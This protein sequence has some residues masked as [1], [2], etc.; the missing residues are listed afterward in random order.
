MFIVCSELEMR[1]ADAPPMPPEIALSVIVG[2]L[3]LFLLVAF[4][5]IRAERGR[6]RAL[7][8][9]ARAEERTR[10][11]EAGLTDFAG[12]RV[13]VER[14]GREQA[15]LL[16]ERDQLRALNSELRTVREERDGLARTLEREH[17][18]ARGLERQIADLKAAKEE[19]RQ[20]FNETA[21]VLFA[22]HSETF[23]AQNS[24]QIGHL[25]APLKNDLDAFKKSLGDAHVEASKQHGS[26]KEQIEL[27]ARQSA[28]VSKEAENL[29]RALKGGVQMQGAWGEMIVDTILNR[30]GLREGV[31]FTRQESFAD[32]EG[33]ARTDYIVRLPQGDAVVIDSKVSLVDYERYVNAADDG[34]R[35]QHLAA[36]ARSLRTHVKGLASKDYHAKVGTRLDFVIMFVP[37]EAALGVA[38]SNDETLTLD[39]LDQK[40][41][42]AT[43]TTLTTTIQT[44]AAMWKV[45]RQNENA[46]AIADRAG[47]L[48]DKFVN[49]AGDLAD[50]GARIAQAGGAYDKAL[51]KLSGAGGLVRQAEMLK[52]MGAK[53][54]K[55]LPQDL[56]ERAG[57]ADRA[58][59]LRIDKSSAEDE[60][61]PTPVQ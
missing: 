31:E 29:A 13:E 43:P 27:L 15:A 40:V 20:S 8:A 18:E 26:L 39:A 7:A 44:I 6:A 34:A 52:A 33:R 42:I 54:S 16:T 23:K 28:S 58:E 2:A 25:L 4:L 56:L 5:I 1:L 9:L 59:L 32:A 50:I 49:F 51:T 55:S 21:G 47:K 41:A 24:E 57:A 12:A 60:G 45:E 61:S 14:L 36:H 37:I 46:D 19:M 17:A 53:T 10:A 3:F 22:R 11:A 38:L 35:A 30:L 48:Y